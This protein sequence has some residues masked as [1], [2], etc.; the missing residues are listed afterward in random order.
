MKSGTE[1][2]CIIAKNNAKEQLSKKRDELVKS[3]KDFLL[4]KKNHIKQIKE[5]KKQMR[6][7]KK[8]L[9][10]ECRDIKKNDKNIEITRKHTEDLFYNVIGS[11]RQSILNN[12]DECTQYIVYSSYIDEGK[13]LE[14]IYFTPGYIDF[15]YLHDLC[16][17]Q[18][19][20][21]N[22]HYDE[23]K[24]IGYMIFTLGNTFQSEEHQY[25]TMRENFLNM[26]II[27]DKK[28]YSESQKKLK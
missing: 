4:M 16:H 26:G 7:L 24:G 13:I 25:I 18:N 23:Y 14:N 5:L 12:Q 8:Q 9:K 6:Q 21:L 3:N 28:G 10:R 11:M 2:Q 19:I 17:N 22:T 15:N 27:Y 1:L 20:N